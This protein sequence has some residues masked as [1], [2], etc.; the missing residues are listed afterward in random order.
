M[1]IY[2]HGLTNLKRADSLTIK[3]WIAQ[4]AIGKN[5]TSLDSAYTSSR[6]GTSELIEA[7]YQE[8]DSQTQ[9]KLQKAL[10]LL[11]S[12]STSQGNFIV[13]SEVLFSIN[14]IDFAFPSQVLLDFVINNASNDTAQHVMSDAIALLFE[15]SHG[16]TDIENVFDAWFWMDPIPCGNT[17]SLLI[18][19]GLL[20]KNPERLPKLLPRMMSINANLSPDEQFGMDEILSAIVDNCTEDV[21][22]SGL[23]TISK[24]IQNQL[25]EPRRQYPDLFSCQ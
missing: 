11:L 15:T 5:S 9:Q 21:L 14:R 18:F 6:M 20:N 22:Q 1:K 16:I 7:L 25:L 2:E 4:R 10:I 19:S 12:E 3:D 24:D 13:L 23:P 8:A 17:Y